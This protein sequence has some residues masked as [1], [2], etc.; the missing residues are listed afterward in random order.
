MQIEAGKFYK[1]RD[2]R[3]VGPME[4][5]SPRG[6]FEWVD[7]TDACWA[8][9]GDFGFGQEDWRLVSE[10]SDGPVRE[11]TVT[12]REIVEGRYGMVEVGQQNK[13]L[14]PIRIANRN[15]E[16]RNCTTE[17]LREAANILNQIA[18]ALEDA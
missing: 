1:T 17:E 8:S 14:V 11:V 4:R 6:G 7:P 13:A 16:L 3:K 10:W 9:D 2:G 12:R 18:E 5:V 15:G